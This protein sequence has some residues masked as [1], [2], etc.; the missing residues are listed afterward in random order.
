[1][2]Q[3]V[4][5]DKHHVRRETIAPTAKFISVPLA[6]TVRPPNCSHRAAVV[7]VALATIA[8]L[9]LKI[10]W[11]RRVPHSTAIVRT[12]VPTGIV[13]E[14]R[15]AVWLLP[16]TTAHQRLTRTDFVQVRQNAASMK[17]ASM[18]FEKEK[19]HGPTTLHPVHQ[20]KRQSY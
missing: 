12:R 5:L 13:R 14:V 15:G 9:V 8:I 4:E 3:V 18:V 16:A 10:Q 11:H 2:M 17:L 19:C 1:M 6:A 7:L 20:G